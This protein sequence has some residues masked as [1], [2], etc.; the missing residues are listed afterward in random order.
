MFR[1]RV[2]SV[3]AAAGAALVAAAATACT[4][5]TGAGTVTPPTTASVSLTTSFASGGAAQCTAGPIQWSAAALTVPAGPGTTTPSPVTDP[6]H[7]FTPSAGRCQLQHR[8]D[9]LRPGRW[10]LTVVAG[11]ASGTCETDLPAGLTF[12]GITGGTCS[13]RP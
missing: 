5:A 7:T 3:R 1:T 10:R 12:V 9:D 4:P 6:F 13:T 2:N 8:F 11:V